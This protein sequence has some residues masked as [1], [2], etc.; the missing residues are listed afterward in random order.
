MLLRRQLARLA[1]R[2]EVKARGRWLR[3][4]AHRRARQL[5]PVAHDS[6]VRP[7][8]MARIAQVLKK[9]IKT[10]RK[11]TH[12]RC[13]ALSCSSAG[14]AIQAGNQRQ[15]RQNRRLQGVCIGAW[16]HEEQ[17]LRLARGK[18][19]GAGAR[20]AHGRRA[21]AQRVLRHAHACAA[22]IKTP[23][24]VR[25]LQRRTERRQM[26]AN[27]CHDTS[28]RVLPGVCRPRPRGPR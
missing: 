26:K 21:G 28:S 2:D 24:V 15:R 6:V 16:I 8:D 5:A 3:Q 10:V 14:L 1:R 20:A 23:A 9:G 22:A 7:S 12:I 25:A 27:R 18:R 17:A 4:H 19:H 11:I 13:A